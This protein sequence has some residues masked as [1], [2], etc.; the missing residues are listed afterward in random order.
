M[1]DDGL[2]Y[3]TIYSQYRGDDLRYVRASKIYL[4]PDPHQKPPPVTEPYYPYEYEEDEEFED[5]KEDKNEDE[6]DGW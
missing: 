4:Q 5:E 6:S 3:G 2:L 1:N